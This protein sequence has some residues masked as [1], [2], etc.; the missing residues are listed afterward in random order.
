MSGELHW[1]LAAALVVTAWW[2]A[3]KAREQ[4]DAAASRVCA[5]L[6]CQRLDQAVALV[7]LWPARGDHGLVLRRIYRFEFS[8]TGADRRHGE[9]GLENG[10]VRWARLEHPD[11]PLHLDLDAARG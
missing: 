2:Y 10:R 4:V 8:V 9:I 5:D 11:G 1:L 7:R 6:G 3:A